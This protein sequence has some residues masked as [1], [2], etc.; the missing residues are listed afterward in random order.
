MIQIFGSTSRNNA[1]TQWRVGQWVH[2]LRIEITSSF[3]VL[4]I[5]LK[6]LFWCLAAIAQ[7]VS[8]SGVAFSFTRIW[9]HKGLTD[10]CINVPQNLSLGNVRSQFS[11]CHLQLMQFEM[12]FG[13]FQHWCDSVSHLIVG[14]NRF[15]RVFIGLCSHPW[16]IRHRIFVGR[17]THV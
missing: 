12:C 15:A 8:C 7:Q 3:L 9:G 16:S 11:F 5:A 13:D 4:L 17:T 1:L 14:W 2:R 6:L 10:K